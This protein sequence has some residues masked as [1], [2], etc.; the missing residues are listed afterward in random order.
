MRFHEVAL[1][2]FWWKV[3]NDSKS[4]L[5]NNHNKNLAPITQYIAHGQFIEKIKLDLA[6]SYSSIEPLNSTKYA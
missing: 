3:S 4:K 2:W 1:D 6:S 5:D